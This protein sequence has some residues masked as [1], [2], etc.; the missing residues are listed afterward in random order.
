MPRP[1]GTIYAIGAVGTLLAR[2][3]PTGENGREA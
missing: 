1:G 3:I 2:M